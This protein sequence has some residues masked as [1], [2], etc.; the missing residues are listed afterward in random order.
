[1]VHACR[2]ILPILYLSWFFFLSFFRFFLGVYL[3]GCDFVL[4]V[5]ITVFF[6]FFFFFFIVVVMPLCTIS[7][8]FIVLVVTGFYHFSL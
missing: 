4:E 7:P 3:F 8:L 6:F 1:M 5:A 2:S